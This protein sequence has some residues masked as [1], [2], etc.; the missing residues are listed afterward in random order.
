MSQARIMT[1]SLDRHMKILQDAVAS[2]SLEDQIRYWQEVIVEKEKHQ[3][4]LCPAIVK[5]AQTQLE[6]VKKRLTDLS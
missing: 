2:K 6:N 4:G 3:W 1:I 5:R